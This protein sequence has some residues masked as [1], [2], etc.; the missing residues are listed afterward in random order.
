MKI[1]SKIMYS[2]KAYAVVKAG[3]RIVV[4]MYDTRI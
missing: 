4:G 1:N 3:S 2:Q